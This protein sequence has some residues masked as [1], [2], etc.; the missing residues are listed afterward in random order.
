MRT[1][2]NEFVSTYRWR[3]T[4]TTRQNSQWASSR[5][6]L[7]KSP[8][9]YWRDSGLLHSL[10]R[11]RTMEELLVQPGVGVSWE[12][13]VIDQILISLDNRGVQYDGPYY[14]RTNDGYEIDL[15]LGLNHLPHHVHLPERVKSWPPIR[16]DHGG[17]RLI[18]PRWYRSEGKSLRLHKADLPQTSQRAIFLFKNVAWCPCIPLFNNWRQ[19]KYRRTSPLVVSLLSA[20]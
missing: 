14:L 19:L 1:S 4:T 8:K 16:E 5:K 2:S 18:R 6:R 15:V 11:I 13:W 10:L 3:D 9:V 12:G 20:V 7:V 17:Q